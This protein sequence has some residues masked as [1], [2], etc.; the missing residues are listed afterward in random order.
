MMAWWPVWV[1][2]ALL[3]GW[4]VWRQASLRRRLRELTEAVEQRKPFLLGRPSPLMLAFGVD[5]LERA[6]LTLMEENQ[7]RTRTAEDS[8]QQIEATLRNL[9]EGVVMIDAEQRVLLANDALRN[10][11]G[12]PRT[13]GAP[14]LEALVPSA[15]FLEC[16]R[17]VRQGRAVV[18]RE[19]EMVRGREAIWL[20]VTGAQV[21]DLGPPG[22]P[23][24]IFVLHD[25]TR[26]KRLERVRSE[27]VANVSHE[28]RTPVTIIKG[29]TDT[30]VDDH[31]GLDPA[32]RGRF[33]EKVQR[34]TGRLHA[35]LEDL[36]VLTQLE[37]GAEPDRRARIS[38][39]DF[40][41]G[42][43]EDFKV[44]PDCAGRGV[45]TLLEEGPDE[46]WGETARL[47]QVLENL[48][49]NAL[50]HAK[51][52]TR[53]LVRVRPEPATSEVVVSVEDNGP[54]IP[55]TDLPHIFERFYRVD[56]GRSRE[57]GGTGLGLSI[58]KHI[59]LQHGGRVEAASD[60]GAGT[61]MRVR[62]PL[63]GDSGA[64]RKASGE[65]LR[66]E[67]GRA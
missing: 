63:I 47:H 14:K 6:F 36:L 21:P 1:P 2:A 13:T 62:L 40:V 11:T 49:D 51:G 54:G 15:G 22:R 19:I 65:L 27:F 45:E 24:A 46:I 26:L 66:G 42:A 35:M 29:F 33:L 25:I 32:T 20:E 39:R 5:R 30:L 18:C 38:L 16:V 58:V 59:V 43:V 61:R 10:L 4:L 57:L 3:I 8:L 17:E 44:R 31:E 55:P 37:S 28:L 53:I 64:P 56:K 9:Q 50:R 7:Q 48:L 52:A 12:V 23:S 60:V 34:H 67:A 41:A